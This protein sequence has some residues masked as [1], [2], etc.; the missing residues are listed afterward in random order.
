MGTAFGIGALAPGAEAF[1]EAVAGRVL[2]LPETVCVGSSVYTFAET[3]PRYCLRAGIAQRELLELVIACTSI[4][5]RLC[6]FVLA[7]HQC[8]DAADAIWHAWHFASSFSLPCYQG[9]G[10]LPPGVLPRDAFW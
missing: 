9:I 3:A 4:L 10:K 7:S 1:G 6:A 8:A 2:T 5:A